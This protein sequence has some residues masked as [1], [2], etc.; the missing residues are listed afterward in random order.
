MRSSN[1]TY[2]QCIWL[3]VISGALVIFT[4]YGLS[5][6]GTTNILNSNEFKIDPE[7]S[8]LKSLIAVLKS[9]VINDHSKIEKL[10]S[11]VQ[12]LKLDHKNVV[13]NKNDNSLYVSI[14]DDENVDEKSEAIRSSR[15]KAAIVFK[16]IDESKKQKQQK[17]S[18]K[19]GTES[20]SCPARKLFYSNE[21]DIQ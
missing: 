17:E 4:I 10:E 19:T 6:N 8:S 12:E 1:L 7:I 3:T 14:E 13:P 2:T 16:K 20:A 18:R 15:N 9:E 5:G 11:E 21:G